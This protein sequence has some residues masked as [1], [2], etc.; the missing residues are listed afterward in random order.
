LHVEPWRVGMSLLPLFLC[1]L[2]MHGHDRP[3]QTPR[4]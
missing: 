4:G 2:S 1:C 3:S